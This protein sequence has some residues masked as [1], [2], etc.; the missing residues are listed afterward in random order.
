MVTFSKKNFENIANRSSTLL[1]K[2]PETVVSVFLP[3]QTKKTLNINDKTT[4]KQLILMIADKAEL[5]ETDFF[6]ICEK[7]N[8][9]GN[10]LLTIRTLA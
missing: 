4:T 2:K 1:V 9:G 10:Q 6:E 5:Q 3:D 8:D 7:T